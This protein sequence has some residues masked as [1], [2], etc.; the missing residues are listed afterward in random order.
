MIDATSFG[1]GVSASIIF[2]LVA[3]LLGGVLSAKARPD[4]SPAELRGGGA[5]NE[6]AIVSEPA[7]SLSRVLHLCFGLEHYPNYLV[8][9]S[10]GDVA[11]AERLLEAQLAELRR[12][13]AFLAERE[14]R[15][16][17]FAALDEGRG[18]PSPMPETLG[19]VFCDEALEALGLDGSAPLSGPLPPGRP[20]LDALHD[21]L[22]EHG[23]GAF[24]LPLLREGLC[25]SLARDVGRAVAFEQRLGELA[26]RRGV[27]DLDHMGYGWLADLLLSCV[28]RPLSGVLLAE[29][30]RGALDWRQGYVAG[31]SAA[32]GG[33]G[34]AGAHRTFLVPHSDDSDITLSIG[35][36][37]AAS[38]EG[39]EV[40][41]RGLRG[42]REEQR[43]EVTGVVYPGE[44]PGRCLMH[45]G[46]LIHEVQE[47]TGGGP[48]Y[49]LILWTRAR[50]GIRKELCPCCW[51]NRRQDGKMPRDC[52]CGPRWN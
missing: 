48:R 18:G 20:R 43:G 47:V 39:G 7:S 25:R 22:E 34:A 45:A 14:G 24:E 15:G 8:R 40:V 51:I 23:D 10:S 36:M 26:S 21:L 37:G 3:S 44:R 41:L 17:R 28:A 33:G 46:R 31:Y 4:G 35:L 13:K 38:F 1:A 32:P 9:W 27:L 2:L 5:I 6:K 11:E 16:L 12:Q 42:S 49:Q 29:E 52:I 19:G 30:C 50:G